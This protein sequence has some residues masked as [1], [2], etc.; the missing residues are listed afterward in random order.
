MEF[1]N[2]FPDE[3]V[4]DEDFSDK[5]AYE[6]G[7]ALLKPS[8]LSSIYDVCGDELLFGG[9]NVTYIGFPVEGESGTV[10]RPA[11]QA[12]AI[13]IGSKHKEAAWE[14]ICQ[15]LDK[16]YQSDLDDNFPIRR[17]VLEESLLANRTTEYTTDADG[18]Q[19]P[20]AKGKL[21]FA[22]EEPVEIYCVTEEQAGELLHLIES[23]TICSSIDYQLYNVFLEEA[24]SYFS[25]DK[26]LEEAVAVMQSRASI[27][28]GEKVK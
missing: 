17:S 25:G 12:L 28:I 14:F 24:G 3:L 4:W 21:L 18:N 6:N 16:T 2:T 8:V 9:E 23:A 26:T 19:K 13:S 20:V 7:D 11:E 5:Q 1:C 10:I 27:Y 22:G 15:F